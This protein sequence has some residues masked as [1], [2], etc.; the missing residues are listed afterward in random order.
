MSYIVLEF[1]L[2]FLKKS[3]IFKFYIVEWESVVVSGTRPI[4]QR[5]LWEYARG[6]GCF[7]NVRKAQIC[8]LDIRD[9]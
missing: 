7:F 5:I 9:N 1:L 6:G 2:F 4:I 3:S 8:K